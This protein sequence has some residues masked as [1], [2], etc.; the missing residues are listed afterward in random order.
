[1]SLCT[2]H[3]PVS[4]VCTHAYH[5][6]CKIPIMFVHYEAVAYLHLVDEL[7]RILLGLFRWAATRDWEA[8]VAQL[9]LWTI[10]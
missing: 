5:Y 2:Y 6:Y 4:N 8:Y 3:Q 1:M 9:V 7:K 10:S